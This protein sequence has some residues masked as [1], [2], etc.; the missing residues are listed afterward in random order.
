MKFGKEIES[1]IDKIKG[2]GFWSMATEA[3]IRNVAEALVMA[4]VDE[5]IIAT[6][7]CEMWNAVS[8]EY[9]E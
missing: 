4:K 1:S 9:G 5:A 3:R 2:S 7:I 8:C 6:A